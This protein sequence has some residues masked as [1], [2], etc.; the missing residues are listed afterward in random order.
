MTWNAKDCDKCEKTFLY[1]TAISF[2]HRVWK[3]PCQNSGEHDWEFVRRHP[4]ERSWMKCAV[5]GDTRELTEKEREEYDVCATEYWEPPGGQ[6]TVFKSVT[7][8]DG[9]HLPPIKEVYGVK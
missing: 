2:S 9:S 5:C 6:G 3:A 7:R 1:D 4:R 8:Q